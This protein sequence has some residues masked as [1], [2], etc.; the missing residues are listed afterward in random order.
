[1]R[2][3]AC[4]ER[5]VHSLSEDLMSLQRIAVA[6]M[7]DPCNVCVGNGGCLPVYR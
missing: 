2:S 7:A 1:M 6:L 3:S 4:S 5:Q